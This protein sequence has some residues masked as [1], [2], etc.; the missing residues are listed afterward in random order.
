MDTAQEA[1]FRAMLN[2]GWMA[3][4][5]GNVEAPTGYFGHMTNTVYELA[6]IRDAFSET[7]E[8]YGNPSDDDI[9]GHWIVVL[10]SNGIIWIERQSTTLRE[11]DSYIKLE[12][13]F[14][15]WEEN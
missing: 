3:E 8:T 7:I 2:G 13:E 1:L 15:K 6:E 12:K 10:D 4:S 11:W 9:V 14:A 5:S